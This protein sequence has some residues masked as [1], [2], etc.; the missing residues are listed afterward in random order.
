VVVL[1]DVEDV[2]ELEDEIV[3][4]E[5]LVLGFMVLRT[6]DLQQAMRIGTVFVDSA[7]KK[8]GVHE[9]MSE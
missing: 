1:L 3:V 9:P 4:I 8:S 7:K 6:H 2:N 5:S